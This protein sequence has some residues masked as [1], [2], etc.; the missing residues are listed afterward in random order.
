MNILKFLIPAL[1][2]AC[3]P[4]T[5]ELIQDA[6]RTAN[7]SRVGKR[8]EAESRREDKRDPKLRKRSVQDPLSRR[9]SRRMNL[10]ETHRMPSLL[11]WRW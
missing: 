9:W 7:W 2:V 3:A 5:V 4:T 10:D 11:T 8:L 6:Q 1:L